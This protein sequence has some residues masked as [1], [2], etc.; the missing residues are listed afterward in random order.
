[1]GDLEEHFMLCLRIL[2]KSL[3]DV[4]DEDIALARD[5]LKIACTALYIQ[6]EAAE[7]PEAGACP[8]REAG[9]SR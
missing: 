9:V 2:L 1:M 3:E 4:I 5:R 7:E 8:E 6:Q